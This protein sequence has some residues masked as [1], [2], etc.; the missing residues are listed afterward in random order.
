MEG[1]VL[2][3]TGPIRGPPQTTSA[4]RAE[5]SNILIYFFG[6][7]SCSWHGIYIHLKSGPEHCRPQPQTTIIN[8]NPHN[9]RL[10]FLNDPGKSMLHTLPYKPQLPDT[11]FQS[12]NWISKCRLLSWQKHKQ[13]LS[14]PWHTLRPAASLLSMLPS[15]KTKILHPPPPSHRA[16]L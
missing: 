11:I 8:Q 3:H 4:Q 7:I 10:L 14:W 2:S 13:G 12:H 16:F 5:F 15:L 1:T 6:E 9:S